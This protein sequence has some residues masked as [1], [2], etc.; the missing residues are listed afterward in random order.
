MRP[1]VLDVAVQTGDPAGFDVSD[2]AELFNGNF[3]RLHV[4]RRCHPDT[5]VVAHE[6]ERGTNSYSIWS[7]A[8][9]SI[10]GETVGFRERYVNSLEKR[11]RSNQ[12]LGSRRFHS[13]GLRHPVSL[14]EIQVAVA[15][16][17]NVT[18]LVIMGLWLALKAHRKVLDYFAKNGALL[19]L[20]AASGKGTFYLSIWILTLLRVGLFFIASIPLCYF[21]FTETLRDD[22]ALNLFSGDIYP[23]L[24]WLPAMFASFSLATI[25]ASIA[26]L[27]ER[28]TLLSSLYRYVPLVFCSLGALSWALSF[29]LRNES[30]GLFREILTALPVVGLA[31]VL[32]APM[33]VPRLWTLIV[34]TILSTAVIIM[35]LKRNAKW[36]AAHL[37]E[38]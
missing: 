35:L 16:V 11:E 17:L 15:V 1:D 23:A 37:E 12:L 7:I 29:L 27:K 30:A 9:L 21:L 28:H 33:I 18:S 13:S 22:T 31:P 26:D 3:E 14:E 6:E 19:P 38:L 34:H 4:C 32:V 5:V 24:W 2:Y 20:V 36:F 8:L 25:V 10:T